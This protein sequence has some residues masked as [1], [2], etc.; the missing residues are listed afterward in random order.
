MKKVRWGVLGAAKIAREKVI[1]A[2]KG[3]DLYEV[4]AIGSRSLEKAKSAAD[5]W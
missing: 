1:P 5:Q 2:M 4:T 3:S